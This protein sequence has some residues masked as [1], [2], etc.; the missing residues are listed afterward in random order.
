MEARK[1]CILGDFAVG[2]TS[3]VSRFVHSQFS[4]SYFASIGIKV[5]VKEV[6]LPDGSPCKLAVWDVAGTDTP[7][8]L[9]LRYVRGASGYL[10]VADG[11]RA[12]TLDKALELREAIESHLAVLPFVGVVNKADLE[13]RQ[14]ID[15]SRIAQLEQA[16]E[17]WLRISAL[18]GTNVDRAFELLLGE[19][20]AA[21]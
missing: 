8:E 19:F 1:I 5:D 13:G 6:V 18:E 9:F 3:L 7:T 17:T 16:S 15:E 14:E 12:D 21:K 4:Q 11:T 20:G 10:L 2:K